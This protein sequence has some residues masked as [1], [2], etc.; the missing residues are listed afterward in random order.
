MTRLITIEELPQYAP[1]ELK[2]DSSAVGR[3]DFRMRVFRYAPSDICVPPSENFLIVIYRQGVT[4]M[5]R[6]VTGAWKQEHVG[7]G[8]ATLLTRAE[9]SHWRWGNDIEVSHFYISP[10]FLMKTASEAF[11]R[12]IGAIELHDLLGI[13]DPVLSWINEQMVRR[14]RRR[15]SRRKALLRRAGTSG[16]CPHPAKIRRGAVQDAMRARTFQ[17]RTCP[18]DRGLYPAEYFPKHHARRTSG[19]LQ[20]HADSIRPQIPRSLRHTPSRL[21]SEK[22]SRTSVP[23]S[24]KGQSGAQ[25]D[26]TPQWLCRPESSEQGLSAAPR[27]YAGRISQG[28]PRNLKPFRSWRR[29]PTFVKVGKSVR[30]PINELDASDQRKMVT[31]SAPK[32]LHM[33]V[34]EGA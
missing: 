12:D 14:S 9:P 17:A 23:A 25:G 21:C 31:S 26:R 13:D 27:L 2:L 11:D 28:R 6:R 33:D 4:S 34:N 7:R 32:R 10:A 3:P 20:L 15:R 1:G 8:I 18:A 30:C 29:R 24:A 16:E 22:E 19:H 5:N